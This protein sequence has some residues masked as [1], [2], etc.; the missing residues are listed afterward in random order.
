MPA[1]K[2]PRQELF[3]RNLINGAKKGVTQRQA[4]IEAG[5]E[6]RGDYADACASRLA[7]SDKV[8]ARM[9][10]IIRPPL[11]KSRVTVE[12]LLAELDTTVK[13]AREAKQ[14]AVVVN[15]LK[16]MADL[17]GMLRTQIEVGRVGEF[18]GLTPEQV[19]EQ[20]RDELGEDAAAALAALVNPR[21]IP[22]ASEPEQIT[23]ISSE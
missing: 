8:K 22:S 17:L 2:R 6:A 18:D 4:Y 19:I 5:Y 15:A 1:L 13:D 9:D 14:H 10:E 20:I 12:S 3:V 11:R 21:T 16:L 7:S 23:A